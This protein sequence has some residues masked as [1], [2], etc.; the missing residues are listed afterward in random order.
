MKS[1]NILKLDI[2]SL[3]EPIP[4][5]NPC[6]EALRYT[7]VYDKIKEARREEDETLPQGIWKTDLKKADW[8]RVDHL[9]REALKT[10]SKDLQIALWLTEARLRLEG[11]GGLAEGLELIRGL[12][13]TYWDSFYPLQDKG[14]EELRKSLY[15]W[16]NGRLS[17]VVQF[18]LISFPSDKAFSSY[19]FLD[20]NEANRLEQVSQKNS[21][22]EETQPRE[23][24][25]ASLSKIS[26]SMD[27]TPLSYYQQMDKNC[28]LALKSMTS[29]EEELHLHLEEDVPTFYRLREKVESVQRFV[30]HFF[31]TKRE[32]KK[33][34][35]AMSFTPSL[36]LKES[37]SEPIESREKAYALLGEIAAYLERIE[38]H[39]PTPYLIHR[40]IS[41]GNMNLSQVVSTIINEEG[42]VSLLLDIL[43]VKKE[44]L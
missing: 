1:E 13:Q 14:G 10:K 30:L 33:E 39:S 4:G 23:G 2:P 18:I 16:I 21:S 19:R 43:N 6:G 35:K 42:D 44:K 8:E 22:D 27:Q 31:E 40:A 37:A 38:P 34:K 25:Q 7:D 3:L 12:T 41:W 11:I 29:L 32:Q 24:K 36:L 9:C 26:L 5:E 17:E 15:N 28:A 20:L